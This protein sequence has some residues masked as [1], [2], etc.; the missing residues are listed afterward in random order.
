MRTARGRRQGSHRGHGGE[1]QQRRR[2]R[3]EPGGLHAIQQRFNEPSGCHAARQDHNRAGAGEQ[4]GCTAE[5]R[6]AAGNSNSSA[7]SNASAKLNASSGGHVSSTARTGSYGMR[8]MDTAAG[9]A[10]CRECPEHRTHH[11]F[12]E[13]E[14]NQPLASGS[15]RDA[16]GHLAGRVR[17]PALSAGSR[18]SRAA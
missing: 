4:R 10:P 11:A 5:A 7:T 6:S 15:D 2:D 8:S 3:V 17:P 1:G 18:R 12:G 16:Q 13:H 9:P 14:L